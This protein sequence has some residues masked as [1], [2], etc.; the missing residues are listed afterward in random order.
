[1]K[2]QRVTLYA[3]GLFREQGFVFLSPMKGCRDFY[4]D[5]SAKGDGQR[6]CL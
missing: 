3:K 1:M 2:G 5:K 6:H 4:V